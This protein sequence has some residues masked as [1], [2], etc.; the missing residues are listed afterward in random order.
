MWM[1]ISLSLDQLASGQLAQIH[2]DFVWIF[3]SAGGPA[4]VAMFGQSGAEVL[5]TADGAGQFH[6]KPSI[7]DHVQIQENDG[8]ECQTLYFSPAAAKLAE[9]LMARYGGTPCKRPQRC[10]LFVG[11]DGGATQLLR[12]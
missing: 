12:G 9:G 4:D 1:K 8:A 6:K 2:D 3:S 7:F 11:Q 10:A 5:L